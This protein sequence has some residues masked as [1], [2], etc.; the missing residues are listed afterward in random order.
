MRHPTA[1]P[2]AALRAL[3]FLALGFLALAP[4]HLPA[5]PSEWQDMSGAKFRGEPTEIIGPFALF[6]TSLTTGRRVQ[7]RGL[8]P[9]DTLRLYRE[10][11]KHPARAQRWSEAKS[12]ATSDLLGNVL[13]VKNKTLVPADLTAIPE[14]ELLIVLYGSHNDNESWFMVRTFTAAF[15][16]I[17]RV[18]PGKVGCVFMG[19]RHSRSEHNRIAA[20]SYMPWLV[21]N[22]DAQPSM[23][24]LNRYAPEEGAQ[25]VVLSRNGVPLLGNRATDLT[26]IKKFTDDLNSLLAALDP[27]NPRSWKDRQ[28]YFTLTRPLA[29]SGEKTGPLL[30]GDPLRADGLRQ[31]GITRVEAHLDIAA[32]GSVSQVTLLPGSVVPDALKGPLGDALRKQAVFAP[33]IDHGTAIAGTFDYAFV[34]PPENKSLSADASWLNGD[35]RNEVPLPNWLVLEPIK[36]EEKNFSEVDHV[37]ADD[38][39]MLKAVQVSTAKVSRASQMSAFNTDWFSEAGAGTVNPTPGAPQQIDGNT[40]TWKRLA[41]SDGL[42]D[43]GEHDY[44]VGYAWTEFEAPAD[45]DAWL[46][47]GSDDGVKIWLNGQLVN[48]RW[49]RRMSRLDDDVIPLRLKK[50]KNH[51][52]IKIQNATGG[53]SFIARLRT[54]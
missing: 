48:D 13:S 4:L 20:E 44:S 6:K 16:R 43:F 52:L 39:V 8:S 24:L 9:D 40:L 37:A 18:Y 34:V 47:L 15:E 25:M 28:Q 41:A 45:T 32:D 7:L 26:A 27:A 38:T 2:S 29:F 22:F 5:K 54:R 33:A 17:Q 1:L 46:G 51:L 50:G 19:V 42:V 53:W 10:I 11:A 30:I 23:S 36:V 35:A 21:A 49:V 12:A 14:P 3:T 31:R